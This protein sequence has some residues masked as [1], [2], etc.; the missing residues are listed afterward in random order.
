MTRKM[1]LAVTAAAVAVFASEPQYIGAAKC[2]KM[3]HKSA[4]KGAQYTKWQ[5]GPHSKAF[6]TLGTDEAKAVAKK[7]GVA[8]NPQEAKEC[9]RCH[10][11]A[12][13][14]KDELKASTY[15]KEDGISC[16]SCHG[17]GSDYAKMSIMKDR[18][19]SIAAGMMVPDKQTCLKCH[20]EESP[21]FKPFNYEERLKK[22][23]HPNPKK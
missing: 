1:I 17:A 18:E 13:D 15:S 3:C 14:V 8:G 4:S 10:V 2:A 16:E 22:I 9:L 23:A 6:E 20:N 21:T 19:K 5:E 11:T 7:A 12:F